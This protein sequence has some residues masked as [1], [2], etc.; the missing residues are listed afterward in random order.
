LAVD[1]ALEAHRRLVSAGLK[2]ARAEVHLKALEA[3]SRRY[4]ET[5][6]RPLQFQHQDELDEH[7]LPWRVTRW[8]VREMPPP[9]LG[10]IAGDAVHNMR[11][12][13]D[14]LM[15]GLCRLNGWRGP[16]TPDFPIHAS[17]PDRERGRQSWTKTLR[18]LSEAHRTA[19]RDL[20][21]YRNPGVQS[22][23]LIALSTL[24]NTDKHEIVSAGA[25]AVGEP[26]HPLVVGES[27][28]VLWRRGIAEDGAE[29]MRFMLPR[30]R[31]V[32]VQSFITVGLVFGDKEVP[33][34]DM[35]AMHE[36]VADLVA[37]FA[38]DFGAP[39][40]GPMTV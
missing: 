1:T 24:D 34:H 37:R 7:G 23:R 22:K 39:P 29:V 8:K 4:I 5:D 31:A 2:L 12:A 6:P 3:A 21:P 26:E 11:C 30:H 17:S 14:H 36:V 27:V 40:E 38:P 32:S 28:P 16:R 18:P 25:I 9:R 33:L 20:Q 13:L 10:L 15:A 19:I 35:K